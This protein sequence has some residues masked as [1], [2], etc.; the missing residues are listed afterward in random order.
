M[1]ISFFGAAREV[2]GSCF[3]VE[4]ANSRLLIDCGMFQGER[5]NEKRN[6]QPFDFDVHSLDAV[7]VTHAHLDHTGRLPVLVDQGFNGPIYWTEPTMALSRL[8]L[9][10]A[11]EIM[12][13]NAR[14][15][16]DPTLYQRDDLDKV[17]KLGVS[18]GF[19][20][21]QK[22]GD[23]S[24]MLHDAGHILGSAYV[25]V[26]AEGKRWVFSGDIGND[27]VPILGDTEPISQA[28]FVV[29]ESTYGHRLHEPTALRQ[30]ILEEVIK[31]V[32][33]QNGTLLVPAFSI[34]RTQ[35][36]LF[37][38][39]RLE[40]NLSKRLPILLDSPLAIRATSLYR[41]YASYLLFDTPILSEPDCDFFSFPGLRETLTVEESKKI[42]DLP[43]PKL[44]IA[45]SGMMTGGRILHHLRR[46]LSKPQTTLLIIG[47]QA[48][49]T[50]GRRLYERVPK[51]TIF[52]EQIP[53]KAAVKAIGAFSAH[54]DRDKLTRWL[55]PTEG[56]LPAKIF[57]VHGDDDAQQSFAGHLR[58]EL[59][60]EV[61]IPE[62]GSSFVVE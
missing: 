6:G 50:L 10:D 26:E 40:P 58:R 48:Q 1:K 47:Y 62:Y 30:T 23:F 43:S 2:T 16:G 5:L 12:E 44:V 20:Q 14:R 37:E 7:V 17:F 19:H 45:G 42:N 35:E 38:L 13:D 41:Q 29:C 32:I 9:E 8:V 31:S 18:L 4:T 57:L 25:S 34:E 56:P 60:S 11:F 33:D 28:D 27:D 52:G 39:N 15:C 53:V 46:E 36:L 61:I 3:L 49:G 24:V 54:G 59:K 51:V 21:A 22:I 55:Q